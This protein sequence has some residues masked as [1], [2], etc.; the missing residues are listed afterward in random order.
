MRA[1]I[2]CRRMREIEG[3]RLGKGPT[4]VSGV[5]YPRLWGH[6]VVWIIV[7]RLFLRSEY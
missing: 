2:K 7:G 6:Q 4:R 5:C 3:M 1:T